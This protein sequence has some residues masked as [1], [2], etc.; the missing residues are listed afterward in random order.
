[1][2]EYK[3]IKSGN[4]YDFCFRGFREHD[5]EPITIYKSQKDSG[6]FPAGTTWSRPTKEFEEKFEPYG[7]CENG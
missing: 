3:H 5:L 7:F 4:I 6:D 1:M 2:P